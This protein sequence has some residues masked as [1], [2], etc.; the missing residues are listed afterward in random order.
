MRRLLTGVFAASFLLGMLTG[1]NTTQPMGSSCSSC[2]TCSTCGGGCGSGGCS[3]GTCGSGGCATC[4]G[5]GG[6]PRFNLLCHTTGVCDCDR[7][8]D[9]CAHRAPWASARPASYPLFAKV[10]PAA[11]TAVP[12]AP[13]D[14]QPIGAAP[15]NPQATPTSNIRR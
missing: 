1:C 15:V 3:S 11:P 5:R 6:L 13:I 9:P 10:A 2:A 12:L 7:D 8:E 4:E 14:S